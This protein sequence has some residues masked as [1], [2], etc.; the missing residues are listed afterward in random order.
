MI[1]PLYCD[2]AAATPRPAPAVTA[3]AAASAP[4]APNAPQPAARPARPPARVE[5]AVGVGIAGGSSNWTSDPAGYGAMT[6]GVR[7]F[8]IVTL[9]AGGALGYARVDQRLLTRLTFGVE[10]G[11]YILNRFY[12]RGYVAFV[13]QHEESLAAVAQEAGGALLGIGSGIR[14]RAGVHAG[15]GFDFVLTRRAA[16]D[17]TIGPDVSFT[18]LTYSSGPSFYVLAGATFAGHFRLF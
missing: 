9:F 11:G 10:V 2:V 15:I 6:L 5:L 8:R 7:L 13:H 17:L 14:H 16:F 12:P 1:L 4:T 3:P 18:Y